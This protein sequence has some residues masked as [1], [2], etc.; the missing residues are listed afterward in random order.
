MYS[1]QKFSIL[2]CASDPDP[3]KPLFY[4]KRHLRSLALR[5]RRTT[6]SGTTIPLTEAQRTEV[7]KAI[8]SATSLRDIATGGE[9][10]GEIVGD[11]DRDMELEIEAPEDSDESDAEEVAEVEEGN[12]E[13]AGEAFQDIREVFEGTGTT[14]VWGDLGSP[15]RTPAR[16]VT[17]PAV[18][19]PAPKPRQRRGADQYVAAQ[20]SLE[21]RSKRQRVSR[22]I[23]F[24][25]DRHPNDDLIFG[26]GLD[27]NLKSEEEDC[28]VKKEEL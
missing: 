19:A 1:S 11:D 26:S 10:K 27:V 5:G 15:S 7:E 2:L 6:K 4:V 16:S 22:G 3:T 28:I 23:G 18:A 13:T 24:D 14:S 20:T 8:K 17:A 12:D 9:G 25:F 21:P